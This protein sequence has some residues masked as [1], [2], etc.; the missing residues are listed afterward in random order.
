MIEREFDYY[1]AHQ[2]ELVKKYNGKY[3]V[4]VGDIIEAYETKEQ[5]YFE[6]QKKYDLGTFLIQ[7]CTPG[8]NSYTHTFYSQN[9]AFI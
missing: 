6:A 9:V 8:N 5:A 1:L 3:L 7:L 2:D 4:I